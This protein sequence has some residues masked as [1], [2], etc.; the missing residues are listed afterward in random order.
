MKTDNRDNVH[1][2]VVKRLL[3]MMFQFYPVM[4]PV[5]LVC[6]VFSAIVGSVPAVFMQNIIAV[7]EQSWQ[8][9]DWSSV[10]TKILTL[11]GILIVF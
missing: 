10:S 1:Q 5:T 7:I 4:L 6:I 11:A 3:K 8:S 2:G 9:G